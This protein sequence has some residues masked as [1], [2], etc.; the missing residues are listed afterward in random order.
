MTQYGVIP[1]DR[2]DDLKLT[3]S[4]AMPSK[5]KVIKAEITYGGIEEIAFSA[6]QIQ[7]ILSLEGQFFTTAEAFQTWLKDV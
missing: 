6:E 2:I 7:E 1:I 3:Y 5:W 4:V